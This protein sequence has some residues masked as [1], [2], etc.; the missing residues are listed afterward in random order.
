MD[1][2]NLHVYAADQALRARA[3]A[4]IPGGMY[5][6]QNAGPLPDGFPQF[7]ERARGCRLFDVDGNE[8]IDFMCSYGPIILGHAHPEVEAAAA[9]TWRVGSAV[10]APHCATTA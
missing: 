7:L 3:K 1:R 8:Y 10:A 5:G 2:P 6:H 4:V 9:P